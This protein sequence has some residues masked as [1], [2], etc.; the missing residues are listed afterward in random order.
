M[1]PG[2][3]RWDGARRTVIPLV[4][5]GMVAVAHAEL[6]SQSGVPW[7]MSGTVREPQKLRPGRARGD[8]YATHARLR[9]GARRPRGKASVSAPTRTPGGPAV[10]RCGSHCDDETSPW[11][12]TG[13]GANE[14]SARAAAAAAAAVVVDA[15]DSMTTAE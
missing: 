14:T 2:A 1:P 3:G 8:H 12:A 15:N 9:A 6:S 5:T 13:A 4:C 7:R 11:A 10:V